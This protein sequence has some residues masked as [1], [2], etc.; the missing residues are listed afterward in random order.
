[1]NSNLL[2]KI[3]VNVAVNIQ[4]S[5]AYRTSANFGWTLIDKISLQCGLT[6]F[7]EIFTPFQLSISVSKTKTMT[8]TSP[9]PEHPA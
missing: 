3:N 5:Q 1:M 4:R 8:F 9:A 7:D 2:W 6:L